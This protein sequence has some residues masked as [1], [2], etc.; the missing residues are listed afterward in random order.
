MD[1][2]DHH[3]LV[4]E[5]ATE[6]ARNL[7]FEVEDD[8]NTENSRGRG[9]S[10]SGAPIPLHYLQPAD[11]EIEIRKIS[12]DVMRQFGLRPDALLRHDQLRRRSTRRA[13][14]AA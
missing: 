1:H 7:G 9:W 10:G 14:S 8:L 6:F 3:L 12:L 11:R 2:T 13:R 5:G 4:G